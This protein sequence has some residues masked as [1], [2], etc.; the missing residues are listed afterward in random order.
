MLNTVHDLPCADLQNIDTRSTSAKDVL[1]ILAD[2]KQINRQ[3][4]VTCQNQF[5][6]RG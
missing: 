6:R 3:E 1:F 5:T 2:L 4:K